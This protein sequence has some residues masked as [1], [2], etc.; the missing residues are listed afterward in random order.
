MS[1]TIIQFPLTP[2][3]PSVQHRVA[4]LWHAARA[5]MRVAATRRQLGMLDDRALADIGVSR[6]QAEFV[7]EAP[8]WDVLR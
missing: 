8:I 1:Q 4:H 5:A 3:R 2:S 7:V 6:A